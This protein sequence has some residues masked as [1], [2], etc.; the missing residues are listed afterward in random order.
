MS[1]TVIT[2]TMFVVISYTLRSYRLGLKLFVYRLGFKDAT[3]ESYNCFIIDQR[4]VTKRIIYHRVK[5][6]DT[7]NKFGVYLLCDHFELLWFHN[8]TAKYE[9][10]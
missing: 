9:K 4:V 8:P 7:M 10:K 2:Q 6:N 3:N 5:H 1:F